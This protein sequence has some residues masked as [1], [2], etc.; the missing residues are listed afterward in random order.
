MIEERNQIYWNI[1][2]FS[3]NI[4]NTSSIWTLN[5]SNAKAK[6]DPHKKWAIP[7]NKKNMTICSGTPE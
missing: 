7:C 6:D 2:F 5:Q 4:I 3:D 1:Y